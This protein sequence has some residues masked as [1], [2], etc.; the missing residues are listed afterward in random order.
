MIA[1]KEKAAAVTAATSNKQHS[2]VYCKP[3]PLSSLKE[4]IGELLLFGNEQRREFWWLLESLLIQ[5]LDFKYLGDK[6]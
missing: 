5:Y 6:K 3:V 1:G 2:K 4:Q